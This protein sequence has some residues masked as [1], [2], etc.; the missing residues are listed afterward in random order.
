LGKISL[1]AGGP[2]SIG[3]LLALITLSINLFD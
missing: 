3:N 1:Q 2:G